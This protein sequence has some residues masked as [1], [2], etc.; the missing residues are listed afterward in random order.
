M[1]LNSG[2]RLGPYEIL[3]PLGEGG[4]GEVYRARDTRLDRTVAIKI[5]PAHLSDDP[6]LRQRFEREAKAISSLNHP[7][8][9]VLYDVG[10]QDGTQFLVMECVEGE[11]LAKRLEKGPLPLEQ[12]LKYGTQIADALD[13][14][15]RGGVLHRDLKPGNIMLTATGAKLLDFGLAKAAP[16]LAAGATLTAAATRTTPVTQ[17]GTVVGTFQ[18][19]SPE[20][21]EGKDVDAR[22]DIFS[23]GSVLYE[24]VTGLR[25][26]P[27]KSHLSVASAILEKEP[28]PISKLQPLAPR[29][30]DRTIRVC[31]AKDPEDRWQT[32]RDLLLELRWIAEGGSQAGV[33]AP[34]VSQRKVRERLAWAAVAALAIAA[35]IAAV[36]WWHSARTAPAHPFMRFTAELPPGVRINRF[37]GSQLAISPDGTRIVVGDQSAPTGEWHLAIRWLDQSQFAPLSGTDRAV[38]PFFSPD[39]QWLAFFADGKLKKVP[40]QGGAP[41]TLCDAPRPRGGSWGDDGNIVAAFNGGLSGLVRVSSG[42]GTPTSITQLIKVKGETAQ[43]WPQVLPGS[44]TVLFTA[45]GTGSPDDAEIAV[46]SVK[47]GERKTIYRGGF[48]GRYLPSGHLVYLQQNT[49]WSAAFDLGRL[50]VTAAPQPVLEEVNSNV[51]GGGDFDFSQTGTLVLVSLN[52]QI[53]FPYSIW[54][55]DSTGQ[56]KPLQSPPGVYEDPEFSP[57]GKRL[58]F[59]LATSVARADIWVKDLERD[60]VSRLTHLPGRNIPPVWTPDGKSIVFSSYSQGA[61]GIYWIRADGSGEAQRLTEGKN[62]AFPRSFSPDGKRLAYVEIGADTHP[63]IW[64]AAVEGDRDHPRLGKAEPFQRTSFSQTLPAFSPDGHWLAYS[65][66]ESGSYELYVQPFPGPGGKLQIST[67]GGDYPIWSR[68]GRQLFFLTPDWRIMVADYTA[69]GNSFTAGKPQAWSQKNLIFLGG[70]YPYDLAPDGKRFAVVLNAE[71]TTEQGQRPLDSVTVLLNFFDELRR[72]VPI[73][74]N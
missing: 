40:V 28:E 29:A 32:V 69:R 34:I 19:M 35:V 17:R 50:A 27:G 4:M 48:F 16:P 30:L 22:T 20:Q 57:D 46:V 55:L 67:G 6:T 59:E 26:F 10:N 14:A 70:N 60:T 49:V 18:Y 5:L 71:T 51:S 72:K 64:T 2:S 62:L 24:M 7:H 58:A 65:S 37:R 45:Y 31:L 25:A 54:W 61:P 1:P 33:P 52:T 42:G 41:V 9:C 12:V 3:A 73:G 13:K 47:T 74:K 53:S 23:F 39:S 11:T 66:N 56:T 21:V 8:I 68:N 15:H 38:M 44:Q 43:G 36:G 63:Q